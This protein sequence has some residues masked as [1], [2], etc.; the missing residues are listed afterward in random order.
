MSGRSRSANRCYYLSVQSFSELITLANRQRMKL[1]VSGLVLALSFLSAA[2]Q[3][4][5]K[6]TPD[7]NRPS[8]LVRTT[9]R[10]EVRRFAYGGTLTVV[11]PPDGSITVEG[12]PRN[13]V[14][15]SAEI[16]LNADSEKN[17]DLLAAVNTFV[18]DEDVNHLRI[19]T[20]GTHD[21][22]FM[23][24]VARK[25]PKTLLGLPWR[26]DYRIRVPLMIDLEINSGRGPV[27]ISD[28]E[29]NVRVSATESEVNLKLT[30]G[31]V[32]ATVALGKINMIIPMR[33]WRGNGAELR[34]AAG[35]VIV[36]LPAGFNAD[37]DA[38]VLRTGRIV[39]DY[40][41]L[42]KRDTRGVPG[43]QQFRVRAG[44]GGAFF[45]FT[46]GDGTIYFK[47][48]TAESKQ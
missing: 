13:E 38:D 29:G 40:G 39:D 10:H 18:L 37:I 6:Q 25:F 22:V 30:G 31:T 47:K 23:K 5:A 45:Q 26:I 1:F 33:S 20:T 35:D 17:L 2:A 24:A 34:L 46:V 11:G 7:A 15:I 44:S 3:S 16:Q 27:K 19:L 14:D 12:W 21:K 4:P 43:P 32:S 9:S 36:E 42:E 48:Q 41:A 28:V 8:P